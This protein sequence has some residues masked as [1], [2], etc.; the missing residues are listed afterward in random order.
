MICIIKNFGYSYFWID[1][2][3]IFK[4][5][6][7]DMEVFLMYEVYGNV[8]F[9]FVVLFSFK[10]IDC[11]IKDWLVWLYCSKVVKLCGKWFY[12]I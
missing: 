6:N 2:V 4:G 11:M 1:N 8:V 9:I 10:V 3:C 5:M 12:N 7:W